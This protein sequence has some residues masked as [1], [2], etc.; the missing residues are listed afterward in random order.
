VLAKEVMDNPHLQ[1]F[2]CLLVYFG[3]LRLGSSAVARRCNLS[4]LTVRRCVVA[5]DGHVRSARQC[6]ISVESKR[7]AYV[8]L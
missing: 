1:R 4:A 5:P 8:G 3:S 7:L 6:F 2:A